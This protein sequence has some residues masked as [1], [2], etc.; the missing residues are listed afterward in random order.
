[1]DKRVGSNHTNISEVPLQTE[2]INKT[3]LDSDEAYTSF[4]LFY[5]D[6]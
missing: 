1:M 6:I 3:I 4:V 2:L 5:F